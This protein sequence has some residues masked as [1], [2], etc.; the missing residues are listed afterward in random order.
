[1]GDV[2]DSRSSN[3]NISI[4][5][6]SSIQTVKYTLRSKEKTAVQHFHRR[7]I[8]HE[9]V[10]R[11]L[12]VNMR[13]ARSKYKAILKQK[14]DEQIKR[15]EEL[16]LSKEKLQAKKT[17]RATIELA[18]KKAKLAHQKQRRVRLANLKKLEENVLQKD[19]SKNDSVN[20]KRK[21]IDKGK[22]N[23]AAKIPRMN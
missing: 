10:S 22:P 14:N 13:S 19:N 2:L 20:L 7:D 12:S 21:T 23:L 16:K 9:P 15:Q 3:M 17:A 1:M 8:L 18:E 4:S 6:F 11:Q 5:T